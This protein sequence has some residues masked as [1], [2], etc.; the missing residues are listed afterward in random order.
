MRLNPVNLTGLGFFL[1]SVVDE[2]NGVSAER[3]MTQT[4]V[5]DLKSF[6]KDSDTT[7]QSDAISSG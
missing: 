5:A 2:Y 3:N 1:W 7:I 4:C 6:H